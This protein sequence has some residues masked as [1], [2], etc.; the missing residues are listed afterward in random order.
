MSQHTSQ[1]YTVEQSSK[2]LRLFFALW[3]DADTVARLTAWAR[4]A[5]ELCGGRMM[6]PDTLHLTLAF[7]GATPRDQAEALIA[8]ARHWTVSLA[9]L[10]L[11]DFGRF[12]GPRI[13]WAG[14]AADEGRPAW[15]DAV[16]DALWSRLEPLGWRRPAG[17]FRPHVSLLRNAG[18]GDLG[19]L[20]RPPIAWTPSQC[21]LVA[22]RPVR[23]MAYYDVL[24]RLPVCGEAAGRQAGM[25]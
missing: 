8:Q 25:R 11:R 22:S 15:L 2:P 17:I 18:P 23:G 1:D 20:R 12:K 9:P 3:P 13:V 21:V 5:E 4:A 10:V 19:V 7:L 6:R 14:P 16:H 24:A